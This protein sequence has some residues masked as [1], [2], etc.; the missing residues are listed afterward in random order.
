M[1]NRTAL[2]NQASTEAMPRDAGSDPTRLHHLERDAEFCSRSRPAT[3]M[4]AAADQ[5]S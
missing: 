3:E 2:W 5:R 4:S 1:V